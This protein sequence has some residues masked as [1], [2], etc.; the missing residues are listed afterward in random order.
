MIRRFTSEDF[1]QPPVKE[2][3][4]VQSVF[5]TASL[6]GV[7]AAHS[8]RIVAKH[9]PGGITEVTGRTEVSGLA[10]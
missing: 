7:G 6:P 3:S 10:C 9:D 8:A 2:G 4:M 5:R 1:L